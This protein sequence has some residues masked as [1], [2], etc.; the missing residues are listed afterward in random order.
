LSKRQINIRLTIQ[1]FSDFPYSFYFCNMHTTC[2]ARGVLDPLKCQIVTFIVISLQIAPPNIH[3]HN[4]WYKSIDLA[5][6]AN[7]TRISELVEAMVTLRED[8]A[9]DNPY[10]AIINLKQTS[11]AKKY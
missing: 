1:E 8:S 9:F 4:K 3:A 5:I 6:M 10:R 11:T 7:G 2:G